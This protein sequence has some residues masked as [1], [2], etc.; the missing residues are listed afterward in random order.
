MRAVEVRFKLCPQDHEPR[1]V[2]GLIGSGEVIVNLRAD[3]TGTLADRSDSAIHV[4][5]TEVRKVL[6]EAANH[7]EELVVAWERMHQ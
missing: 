5:K 6:R 1:H 2:H 4:T 7:F 3:G